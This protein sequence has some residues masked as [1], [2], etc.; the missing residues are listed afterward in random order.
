MFSLVVWFVDHWLC[1]SNET[2]FGNII[3]VIII[4]YVSV[5]VGNF[6]NRTRSSCLDTSNEGRFLIVIINC[7]KVSLIIHYLISCL[8]ENFM[9]L[10]N[11][12]KI[13]HNSIFYLFVILVDKYCKKCGQAIAYC[14][15]CS[16]VIFPS[17]K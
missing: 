9:T 6:G 5:Q 11:I 3:I 10:W 4:T 14:S 12:K 2:R 1:C 8:W 15:V 7:F 16:T 13:R 17:C